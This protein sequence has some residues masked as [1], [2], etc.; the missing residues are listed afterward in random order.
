MDGEQ[1]MLMRM[2]FILLGGLVATALCGIVATLL[3]A[4]SGQGGC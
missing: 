2:V 1:K 3:W 4:A